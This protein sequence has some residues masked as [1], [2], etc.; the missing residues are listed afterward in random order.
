MRGRSAHRHR[1]RA[2][3]D[4][5]AARAGEGLAEFSRE[6]MVAAHLDLYAAREGYWRA[7]PSLAHLLPPEGPPG[8]IGA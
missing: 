4:R 1:D 8:E 5:L 3:R 2:A 7:T 6:A